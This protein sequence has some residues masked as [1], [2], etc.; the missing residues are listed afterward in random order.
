MNTS[1][2]TDNFWG[3][4]SDIDTREEAI[5]KGSLVDATTAAREADIKYPTA[6]T[7]AVW[8]KYVKVPPGVWFQDEK[9]RLEDIC[10]SL[11]LEIYL[12]CDQS[13]FLFNLFIRNDILKPP[14]KVTLK[15]ICA[16][17]D[18]WEPVFTI[19]MPDEN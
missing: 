4:V 17:G 12:N 10:W 11:R 18:D 9:G 6:L 7:R 14:Q 3:E 5:E 13:Y 15:F 16:P 19:M 2:N 1:K 8:D